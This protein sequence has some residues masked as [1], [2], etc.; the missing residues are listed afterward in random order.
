[1]HITNDPRESKYYCRTTRNKRRARAVR[2]TKFKK[3]GNEGQHKHNVK[4]MSKFKAC[5]GY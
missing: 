3:R 2:R 4:V 1:M 5:D